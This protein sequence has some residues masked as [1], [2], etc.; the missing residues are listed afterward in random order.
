MASC[1]P[2]LRT[3]IYLILDLAL[4]R[5]PAQ[6]RFAVGQKKAPALIWT[7]IDHLCMDMRQIANGSALNVLVF[8]SLDAEAA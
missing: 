4:L 2:A 5:L 8:R 3:R 6:G 1:G 7:A